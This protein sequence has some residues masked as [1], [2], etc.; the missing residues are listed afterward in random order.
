[1]SGPTPEG[2]Q[3][4][5]VR[6]TFGGQDLNL[7][8]ADT[9]R[10]WR[11]GLADHELDGIDG[12]FFQFPADVHHAFHM[13]GVPTPLLIAFFTHDGDFADV[14]WLNPDSPPYTPPQPYRYVLEL[15]GDHA[16]EDGAMALL[17]TLVAGIDPP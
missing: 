16:T 1:M 14:A 2:Q 12:M 7:Y 6:L 4:A 17:P 9:P 13:E 3:A 11:Q 10:A 15:V 8:L 5:C